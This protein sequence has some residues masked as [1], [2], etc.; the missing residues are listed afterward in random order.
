M[1][2]TQDKAWKAATR[3]RMAET[4]EPYSVARHAVL[5]EHE[6]AAA[7][8]PLG[9]GRGAPPRDDRWYA[10]EAEEAGVTVAEFRVAHLADLADQARERAEEAEETVSVAREAAELAQQAAD[11]TRGWADK[12]EQERAQR[13]ADQ[14]RAAAGE[15]QRRAGQVQR[16]ADEAEEAADEAV[17]LG[18]ET[19]DSPHTRP[20][21]SYRDRDHD[22]AGPGRS[23]HPRGP[24]DRLQD[25]L[26][27]LLGRFELLMSRAGQTT[28]PAH[29]E[30]KDTDSG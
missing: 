26:G 21:R 23:R 25:R 8:D 17:D 13:R 11:M 3:R 10:G 2:M 5:R 30:P 18:D 6:G 12:Q 29:D 4:G 1:I 19:G 24:A 7:E 16:Q 9:A 27:Q 28:N 15:A 14:A 20:H 22:G